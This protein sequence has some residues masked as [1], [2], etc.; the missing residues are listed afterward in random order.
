MRFIPKAQAPKAFAG[1]MA[2]SMSCAMSALITFINVGASAF[3]MPWL[4]NW[5]V[6]FVIA[7]PVV[8]VLAP[9]GQRLI[10]RFTVE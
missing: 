3:P 4:R 9:L 8:L 7:F 1:F 2:L 10:A 5:G 6:A